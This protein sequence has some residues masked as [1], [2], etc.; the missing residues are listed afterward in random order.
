MPGDG[1]GQEVM[2]ATLSVLEGLDLDF[3]YV[4]GEAGDECLEKNGVALP[5]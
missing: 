1:I 4:F 5:E 3:D 2:E